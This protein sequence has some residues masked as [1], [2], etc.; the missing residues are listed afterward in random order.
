[1]LHDS[2]NWPSI[3]IPAPAAAT[4]PY[5]QAFAYNRGGQQGQMSAQRPGGVAY[6]VPPPQVRPGV[7]AGL[8]QSPAKRIR[9]TGPMRMFSGSGIAAYAAASA[10]GM[11]PSGI[12]EGM[13]ADEENAGAG[14]LLDMLSPQEISVTRYT[15][16]HEWMEEILSSPY[17]IRQIVPVNLGLTLTGE[18]GELTSGLFDAPTTHQ[19]VG[20]DYRAIKAS[21]VAELEKRVNAYVM[22]SKRQLVEMQQAHTKKMADLKSHKRFAGYE[23]RLAELPPLPRAGEHA[24]Q[25]PA[26]VS[27]KIDALV[28][29]VAR[30]TGA[31]LD[32]RRQVVRVQRGGLSLG[33]D[34]TADGV[35]QEAANAD[36][37]LEDAPER[38]V[39]EGSDRQPT[40]SVDIDV[41]V[42]AIM[43]PMH[44]DH[45][46]SQQLDSNAAEGRVAE[47]ATAA[48]IATIDN[49]SRQHQPET[50]SSAGHNAEETAPVMSNTTEHAVEQ[51]TMSNSNIT[52]T[53]AGPTQSQPAAP[54]PSSVL[55]M[56]S[57]PSPS[58]PAQP[59]L[60]TSITH[61]NLAE[62]T[63][64][65][66]SQAQAFIPPSG[67]G[68]AMADLDAGFVDF[69]DLD[70]AGEALDFYNNF[71]E[72]GPTPDY[73][74]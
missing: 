44:A 35:E 30:E 24:S 31:R 70:T 58:V 55:E 3:T 16:H 32:R 8:E 74:A 68:D 33:T 14:D 37:I 39:L 27:T 48:P 65:A 10:A 47:P 54:A 50:S 59:A 66:P 60:N 38:D 21:Q 71:P 62:S 4:N 9:Q 49:T 22:S 42:D 20:D 15:Q 19:A 17:A 26:Q 7:G 52:T 43:Q 61:Q 36:E 5:Q 1:M 34:G 69:A 11:A 64:T 28:A 53:S 72:A 12:D 46:H 57:L 73:N 29:E 6:A 23:R 18:L 13:I 40:D 67:D 45:A 41:D 63:A 25:Q 56:E 2:A 51:T